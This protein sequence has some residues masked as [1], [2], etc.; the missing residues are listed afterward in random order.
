MTE[1]WTAVLSSVNQDD[2]VLIQYKKG[3]KYRIA[4][5]SVTVAG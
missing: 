3:L 1:C 4:L 5:I 2:L